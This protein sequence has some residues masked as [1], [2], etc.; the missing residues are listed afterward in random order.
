MYRTQH[1]ATATVDDRPTTGA[2]PEHLDAALAQRLLYAANV[3]PSYLRMVV[4]GLDGGLAQQA[5]AFLAE[6]LG[7]AFVASVQAGDPSLEAGEAPAATPAPAEPARRPDRRACLDELAKL[8]DARASISPRSVR[9]VN[10]FVVK[11]NDAVA[12]WG[13]A[14]PD[15]D[16]AAQTLRRIESIRDRLVE[17]HQALKQ[18]GDVHYD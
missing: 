10:L 1:P 3:G 11:V 12:R 13:G 8:A 6:E 14:F 5:W 18:G 7:N 17:A 15:G 2:T 16:L 4:R 9:D